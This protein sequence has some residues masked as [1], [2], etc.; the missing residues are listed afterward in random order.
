MYSQNGEIDGVKWY[1]KYLGGKD[2]LLMVG[3]LSEKYSCDYEPKFGVDVMDYENMNKKMDR[4]HSRVNSEEIE[5][6][7]L[8]IERELERSKVEREKNIEQ[9]DDEFTNFSE[10]EYQDWLNKRNENDV[11]TNNMIEFM[12]FGKKSFQEVVDNISKHLEKKME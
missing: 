7:N 1:A 5:K 12:L 10:E 8:L 11:L 4:L 6:G 9:M 2:F 3:N